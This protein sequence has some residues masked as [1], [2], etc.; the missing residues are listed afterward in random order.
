[1][2]RLYLLRMSR[3]DRIRTSDP[4]APSN[5]CCVLALTLA[6]RTFPEQEQSGHLKS[7]RGRCAGYF[8]RSAWEGDAFIVAN[9]EV[10]R[11]WTQAHVAMVVITRPVACKYLD[12][13]TIELCPSMSRTCTRFAP[14]LSAS[15]AAVCRKQCAW[16]L[17]SCAAVA[18]DATVRPFACP[19][20][21][22]PR[23]GI[24]RNQ[25]DVF[26]SL[27]RSTCNGDRHTYYGHC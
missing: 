13:V 10:W 12:V 27:R 11:P 4:Q 17:S 5:A 1:L 19:A 9:S 15:E 20:R 23:R 26:L 6:G 3:A 2:R 7:F 24:R 18:I 14:W 21:A 25:I 22:R 16:T 8:D